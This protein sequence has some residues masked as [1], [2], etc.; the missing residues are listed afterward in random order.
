MPDKFARLRA[1]QEKAKK[2]REAV[3]AAVAPL[4]AKREALLAQIQP[5]EAD[6]R[7]VNAEI[8]AAEQP[9]LQNLGNEIAALAKAMGAKSLAA[10]PPGAK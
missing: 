1:L 8:K 10:L 9:A 7:T 5:L 4:H 2:E 6:L 3:L